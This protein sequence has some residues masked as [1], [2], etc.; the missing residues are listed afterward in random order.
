[1][2]GEG[3]ARKARVPSGHLGGTSDASNM[4]ATGFR[5]APTGAPGWG[6][7]LCGGGKNKREPRPL[8]GLACGGQSAR[9]LPTAPSDWL[10]GSQSGSRAES[11]CGPTWGGERLRAAVRWP[12]RA[13]RVDPGST[14]GTRPSPAPRR[15][16]DPLP[17]EHRAAPSLS[18]RVPERPLHK[19]R[20][21]IFGHLLC[22]PHCTH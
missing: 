11:L 16:R 17:E 22:C 12:R 6:Q 14:T 8:P 10:C 3:A 20:C 21:A 15:S 18:Q 19:R 7:L 1:M 4:P 13:G 9:L 2:G 5:A